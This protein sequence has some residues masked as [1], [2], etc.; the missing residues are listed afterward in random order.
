M[1]PGTDHER[2][3]TALGDHVGGA[4]RELAGMRLRVG[5]TAD[6]EALALY[7]PEEATAA[8]GT[9]TYTITHKLKTFDGVVPAAELDLGTAHIDAGRL[10]E[11]VDDWLDQALFAARVD[12]QAI[13]SGGRLFGATGCDCISFG[14]LASNQAGR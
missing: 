9:V 12:D 10:A 11:L 8:D 6:F 4:E 3:T 7:A 5:D 14:R 1:R 2:A 13:R